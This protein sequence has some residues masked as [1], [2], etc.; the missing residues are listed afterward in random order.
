[1]P[2]L[3]TAEPVGQC[4]LRGRTSV[5]SRELRDEC[6]R[7]RHAI[8]HSHIKGITKLR[9]TDKSRAI[10]AASVL[11]KRTNHNMEKTEERAVGEMLLEISLPI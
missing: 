5:S 3:Q 7:G 2:E 4:L 1:M 6:F 9:E 10:I 8:P 11:V